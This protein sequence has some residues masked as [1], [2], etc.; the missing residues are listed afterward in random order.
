ME[1]NGIIAFALEQG[2]KY[3]IV[4]EDLWAV[5]T[6][7]SSS[8]SQTTATVTVP[9]LETEEELE[10][11]ELPQEEQEEEKEPQ[12]PEAEKPAG[13]AEAQPEKK[14][15]SVVGVIIAICCMA[16]FGGAVA[17]L[18]MKDKKAAKR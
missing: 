3:V 11:E 14:E 5:S 16:A 6:T 13:P 12:E 7:T 18:V 9:P 17:F 15:I 8:S 10:K 2:G 1:D 4:T